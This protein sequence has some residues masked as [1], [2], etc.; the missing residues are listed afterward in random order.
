MHIKRIAFAIGVFFLFS[1]AVN[2]S[3]FIGDWSGTISIIGRDGS[4]TVRLLIEGGTAV[5]YFPT[6]AG[7][8]RLV[9]PVSAQYTSHRNNAVFH[10]L[11]SGG[12][13]TETQSFHLS[14]IDRDT[15]EVVWVRMVNNRAAGEDGDPWF[16]TGS[17]FL[18]RDF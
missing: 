6:D 11:N 18:F 14:Q 10:W 12:I 15:L 17:G 7:G 1:S 5:Q 13:W 3:D 16:L 9:E 8:W 4:L 2:A